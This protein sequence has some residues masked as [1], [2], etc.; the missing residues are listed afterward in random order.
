MDPVDFV[1]VNGQ[2]FRWN[3][4]T[5][6]Y[7]FV[8]LSESYFRNFPD[9]DP[10]AFKTQ[11]MTLVGMNQQQ[12]IPLKRGLVMTPDFTIRDRTRD[13]YFTEYVDASYLSDANT[14]DVSTFFSAYVNNHDD[15]NL[16][17]DLLASLLF[18]G[19]PKVQI[20]SGSHNSG[21]STLASIVLSL[22]NGLA[23]R[24]TET[25]LNFLLPRVF[26]IDDDSNVSQEF[27]EAYVKNHSQKLIYISVDELHY[28]TLR[29]RDS[30]SE[31]PNIQG[32]KLANFNLFDW[33]NT[34]KDLIFTWLVDSLKTKYESNALSKEYLM[35]F[36]K[37]KGTM[38]AQAAE[39]LNSSSDESEVITK[40]M[41]KGLFGDDSMF[42]R[43][44]D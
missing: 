27:L 25:N 40:D 12:L 19:E 1:N 41:L 9:V 32:Q 3:D 13:D 14:F 43:K 38:K 34:N 35:K 26:I 20:W 15:L 8:K 16:L 11:I 5:K 31:H 28:A 33:V 17:R 6:L 37:P 36:T 29:F 7:H 23:I 2:Y 44:L 22:F 39:S 42:A 21:K 30:F 18:R 4:E 10:V 24:T